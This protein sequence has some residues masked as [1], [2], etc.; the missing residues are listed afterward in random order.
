MSFAFELTSGPWG[1]SAENWTSAFSKFQEHP[2]CDSL[3]TVLTDRVP[4]FLRSRTNE[5]LEHRHKHVLPAK[6]S[7]NQSRATLWVL[8]T[9]LIVGL[10][11]LM[12]ILIIAS[13]SSKKITTKL[14]G[15]KTGRLREHNQYYQ[16]VGLPLRFLTSVNDNGSHRSL[17]C[18][19]RAS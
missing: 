13:L 8:E 15:A 16:H 4:L 11:S 18:L 19:S 2:F 5:W 14:L 3:W 17:S 9:C 7:N 6:F 12:V 1:H 10:L